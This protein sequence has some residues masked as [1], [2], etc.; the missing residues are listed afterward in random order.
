MPAYPALA[1]SEDTAVMH[2]MLARGRVLLLDAP[3]ASTYADRGEYLGCGA[4]R[5][6]LDGSQFRAGGNGVRRSIGRLGN[7]WAACGICDGADAGHLT[8][9]LAA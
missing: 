9:R 5:G 8:Y 6:D 4:L 2:A 3:W 7:V 1:R